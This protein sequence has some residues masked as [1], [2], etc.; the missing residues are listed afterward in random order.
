MRMI[1]SIDKGFIPSRQEQ[2]WKIV[3]DL[4]ILLAHNIEVQNT[5]RQK[6]SPCELMTEKGFLIV[7]EQSLKQMTTTMNGIELEA[8]DLRLMG[9]TLS[10]GLEQ[11]EI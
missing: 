8:R 5:T 11:G 7:N 10:S 2:A 3:Y 4:K 1:Q 6:A 9:L